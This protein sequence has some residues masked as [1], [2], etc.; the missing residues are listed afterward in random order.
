[1]KKRRSQDP[2]ALY[3]LAWS[4]LDFMLSDALESL[5]TTPAEETSIKKFL[6]DA[7][8]E[9]VAQTNLSV[10]CTALLPPSDGF[11]YIEE[12]SGHS[13]GSVITYWC[14]EGY[15]LV[16]NGKL[17]CLLKGNTFD[18]S[19]SPPHCEVIPKPLDKGFR[20]A[21]IA[22]LISGLIIVAMSIAFAICCLRDRMLK[23]ATQRSENSEEQQPRKRFKFGRGK[24]TKQEAVKTRNHFGKMKHNRRLHYRTSA[25][26][27]CA[28]PGALAGYHNQGLQRSQDNLL[29][30][31]PQS[32]C[33]EIH[34]FPQVVL[35]PGAVPSASMFVHLPQKTNVPLSMKHCHPSLLQDT[36]SLYYRQFEGLGHLEKY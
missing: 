21:V 24:F 26:Y 11:Y 36:P 35:K 8:N 32:L 16:G 9:T 31:A 3:L 7:E 29:K 12:G 17:T 15:Q 22:S 34:I 27:S 5:A 28:H 19:H 13:L 1:M 18:W 33:S 23:G 20:V 30:E 2:T 25:L 4:C 10:Q 6:G 14:T